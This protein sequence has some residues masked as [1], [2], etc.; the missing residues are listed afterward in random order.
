VEGED[1]DETAPHKV[2]RVHAAE[3]GDDSTAMA[4]E[5]T[6]DSR[7]NC[8]HDGRDGREEHDELAAAD[9][10]TDEDDGAREEEGGDDEDDGAEED[11]RRRRHR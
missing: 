2:H 7:C 11:D 10:S 4:V 3:E 6:M 9:R 1:D 5:D 8:R